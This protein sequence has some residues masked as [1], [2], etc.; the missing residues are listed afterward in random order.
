MHVTWAR[1]IHEINIYYYLWSIINRFENGDG[2]VGSNLC[3]KY[4]AIDSYMGY[5]KMQS[6]FMQQNKRM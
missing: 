6:S 5:E 4:E 2:F 3:S 1:I